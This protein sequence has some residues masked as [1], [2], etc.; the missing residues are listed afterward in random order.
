MFIRI[1]TL[2]CTLIINITSPRSVIGPAWNSK[3][4]RIVKFVA[5]SICPVVGCIV[6]C[7]SRNLANILRVIVVRREG[8]RGKS[9]VEGVR[10]EVAGSGLFDNLSSC[11]SRGETKYLPWNSVPR[12]RY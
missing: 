5:E 8:G 2:T 10:S 12:T 9:V 7:V 11:L 4:L 1:S 3:K 6:N